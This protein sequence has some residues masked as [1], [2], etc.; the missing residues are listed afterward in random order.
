VFSLALG[1]GG[2]TAV[3]SI[4]NAML[5][6][7]LPFAEPDRLVRITEFHPKALLEYFQERSRTMEVASVSPGSEMNVTGYGPAFRV[8]ASGV[9]AN[10]FSLL[11]V[12]PQSG[13]IFEPGETQPG[14]ADIAIPESSVVAVALRRRRGRDRPGS[15]C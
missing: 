14:R 4:V 7:P 12:A 6:K 3:F 8:T 1:I 15:Y 2:N 9:S 5:I 11:G 13:R 10:L